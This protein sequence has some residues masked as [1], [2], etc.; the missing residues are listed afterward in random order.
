[1]SK[2]LTA[3]DLGTTKVVTAV[4]EM[5]PATTQG[6]TSDNNSNVTGANPYLIKVVAYEETPV[7]GIMRGEIFNIHKVAEAL[8]TTINKAEEITHQRTCDVILGISGQFIRSELTTVNYR[9]S[10]GDNPITKDELAKITGKAYSNQVASDEMILDVIPQYYNMPDVRGRS[11]EEIIGMNG[12]EIEAHLQLIIGKKSACVNREEVLKRCGL[13]AKRRI[14]SP[15]ASAKA[16]LSEAEMENG[17]VLVDI[18]GGNTEVTIIT[19]NTVREVAV[20]PF[21]G[22]AIT[23]DIRHEANITS[24]W[25]ELIKT[26]RGSCVMESSQE[27]C[28]IV[29]KG[30]NSV[31]EG[32]IEFRLIVSVIEAR[33]SEIF[34][35][36]R[37][38]ID[39]SDYAK[40]INAGVVLTGGSA[41]MED[42]L[43]LAKVLLE[44]KVRL[45]CPRRMLA[46]SSQEKSF[47]PYSSVA[48]G[49]LIEGFAQEPVSVITREAPQEQD[50]GVLPGFEPI[51]EQATD[52]AQPDDKKV[53]RQEK[54]VQNTEAR[55]PKPE[56]KKDKRKKDYS[57][58]I[59]GLFDSPNDNEA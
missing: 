31:N 54:P 43:E 16:T 29:L 15:V 46:D 59:R 55:V 52:K 13:K 51:R 8:Q 19:G 6:A 5:I 20:I 37:Y 7:N 38:I 18:G 57:S 36:V 11:A 14:L 4:G 47:D 48:I 21:A 39:N 26:S 49:L 9:R 27:N 53:E 35:A 33:M 28:R 32:D 24:K 45:G 10:G 3:I 58:I 17:V 50:S 42:I 23:E 40:K 44:R 1:M 41:Y 25:A 2:Y 12:K 30:D 34:E 56:K 22:N